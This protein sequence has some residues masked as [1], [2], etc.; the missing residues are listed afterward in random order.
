MGFILFAGLYAA[1]YI[2]SSTEQDVAAGLLVFG[3]LL[4][5][6]WLWTSATRFRLAS[7]RWR[8]IHF[9]FNGTA[10]EAYKACWPYLGVLVVAAAIGFSG[11]LW[12][13]SKPSP[14]LVLVVIWAALAAMVVLTV[15]VEFNLVRLRMTRSDFGGQGARWKA[16]LG[17]FL[18][19]TGLA[20]ALFLAVALLLG[21]LVAVGLFAWQSAAPDFL[22]KGGKAAMAVFFMVIAFSS[23]I[24]MY[25]SIGPALAY[26]E[27]RKFTLIW[28]TAGLGNVARFKSTLRP[29]PFIRLRIK[30]MLLTI[31]TG[32]FYRP[33]AVVSEYQMKL[34]SVTL[35]VK[36]S[37]EEV[38]GRLS[39]PEGAFGDAVA[40]A[41][42][43]DVI[44]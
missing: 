11:A 10:R 16:T 41:V 12:E 44:G 32:G 40:D 29:G 19:I 35:H 31:V 33:F 24:V 37:L 6:P 42:G 30:N 7:T 18:R 22:K 43:F 28:N 8:G 20:A 38:V 39:Q 25:L 4:L 2:A 27:A 23:L 3:W 13:K 5:T 17:D 15:C 21:G 36:G 26:R 14:V 1:Y 9:H 34:E